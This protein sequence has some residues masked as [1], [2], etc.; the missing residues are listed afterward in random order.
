MMTIVSACCPNTAKDENNSLVVNK[1]PSTETGYVFADTIIYDVIIKNPNSDDT[2]TELCLKNLK[3]EQFIDK[4]FESVYTKKAT[5]YD[6]NNDEIISPDDLRIMEKKKEIDRDRIGKIQ[7]TESWLYND[8]LMIMTKKVLAASLG[9]EVFDEKG[10]L[11]GY[12]H[13]FKVRFN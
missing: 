13:L 12:K 7:F 5:A 1:L 3:R 2:W 6:L 11:I 9:M 8:S 4:L 10:D